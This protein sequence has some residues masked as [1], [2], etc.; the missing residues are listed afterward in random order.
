MFVSEPMWRIN[1]WMELIVYYN[2]QLTVRFQIVTEHK[3]VWVLIKKNWNSV[4]KLKE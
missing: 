3:Q 2:T 4:I 1:Y